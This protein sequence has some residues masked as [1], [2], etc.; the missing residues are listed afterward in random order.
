MFERSKSL[1]L[2]LVSFLPRILKHMLGHKQ[3]HI[4]MQ[5]D[6]DKHVHIKCVLFMRLY[7]RF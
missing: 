4:Y 5:K 2:Q 7:H 1:G 3:M 6:K